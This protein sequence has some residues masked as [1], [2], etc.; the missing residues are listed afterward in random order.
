MCCLKRLITRD[1]FGRRM[2]QETQ[3]IHRLN[4]AVDIERICVV[5]R[6]R[7]GQRLDELISA[8][9]RRG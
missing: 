5:E 7:D 6:L 4:L 3:Q 2:L 1:D 8:G 9:Q